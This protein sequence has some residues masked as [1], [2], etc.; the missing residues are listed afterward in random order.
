[1][2]DVVD[3]P[4]SLPSF[5]QCGAGGARAQKAIAFIVHVVSRGGS[6]QTIR[7]RHPGRSQVK[8]NHISVTCY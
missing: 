6:G 3:P 7:I 5:A 1:M 8:G 4:I 2:V